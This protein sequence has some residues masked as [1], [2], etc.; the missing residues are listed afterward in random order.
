MIFR[1]GVGD[2]FFDRGLVGDIHGDGKGVRA[3]PFDL[4]SRSNGGVEIK[5]GDHGNA[6]LGGKAQRDLLADT[7]GGAGDDA[8]LSIEMGHYRVL[9][10]WF[11]YLSDSRRQLRRGRASDR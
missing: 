5:I 9:S 4:A 10:E 11:T 1:H 3:I 7:A 2:A 8:D 6:A